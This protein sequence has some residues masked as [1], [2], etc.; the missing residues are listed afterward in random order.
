MVRGCELALHTEL[1]TEA[2]LEGGYELPALV[3]SE[4]RRH[5]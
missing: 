3:G 5:A 4:E 1:L 2:G